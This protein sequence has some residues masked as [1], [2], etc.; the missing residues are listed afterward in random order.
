MYRTININEYL[1][2]LQTKNNKKYDYGVRM[3]N[4]LV[5]YK[6]DG[7]NKEEVYIGKMTYINNNLYFVEFPKNHIKILINFFM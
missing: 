4:I 5:I 3:N 1:R 7:I 2:E 6:I